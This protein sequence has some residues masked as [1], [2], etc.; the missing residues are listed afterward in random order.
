MLFALGTS[1][2][3]AQAYPDRA[4]RI[5]DAFPPGGAADYL[6]RVIGPKITANLGRQIVVENRPGAGGTIGA[7]S[8]VKSPPDGYTLFM[9]SL[10]S[11]TAAPSL[12]AKLP[13]DVTKDLAPIG[14]VGA[15]M[16]VVASHPSLPVKS[17]KELIALAKARPGELKYGSGGVGSGNHLSGEMFKSVT[18]T[19]MQHVAYKGSPPAVTAVISGECELGFMSTAAALTQI[20]AGRLRALAVT[21]AKRDPA[22]PQIPTVRESGYPGYEVALTFG[23]FAPAGTPREI[24]MLL[25]SEVGK[26]LAM[27][28]VQER[29]ATQGFTATPSTPEELG[30]AVKAETEQWAKVI[31]A[32][33]IR[34]E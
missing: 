29:F 4:I 7:A 14:R 28:D 15:G 33:G 30:A 9:A 8:V 24:I 18:G 10:T 3:C 32:A 17:I 6:A 1:L 11:I 16:N 31:K 34:I 5:V 23:L 22:L 12:Y 13:Y 21:G 2:A 25:N 27:A 19:D 20:K 26:A